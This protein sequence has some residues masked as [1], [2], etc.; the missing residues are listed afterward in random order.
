MNTERE[1]IERADDAA[2]VEMLTALFEAHGWAFEQVSDDEV[3]VE[4]PGSWTTY[5]LRGIW[6][7]EDRVLQLLCLPE[8]RVGEDKRRNAFEL[9]ALINEQLWLGHFDIWSQGGML[10]YRHGLMLGD[11]G[12]L[13]LDMAQHAIESAIAE[14]DRFYPAFQFVLWGD[15]G[16]REALDAALVDAAGEA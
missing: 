9:L 4:I 7:R 10:L 2:P 11:D 12:M 15:K 3:T 1:I 16:P 5:Q 6:R 13:S 8:I 14:C